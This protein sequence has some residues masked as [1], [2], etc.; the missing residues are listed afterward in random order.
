[1]TD[2]CFPPTAVPADSDA[3]HLMIASFAIVPV[4]V[5]LTIAALT[6]IFGTDHPNGKWE[7]RFKRPPAAT[8]FHETLDPEALG[9][10]NL[11]AKEAFKLSSP[12][13][14]S[15]SQQPEE[16]IGHKGEDKTADTNVTISAV[17]PATSEVDVAVNQPVTMAV[18]S[19][20]ATNPMTWLPSLAYLTTFG[21]ELVMDANLANLLYGMYQDRDLGQTKAGYIAAIYGLLN[22]FSRAFGE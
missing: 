15:R 3:D 20:L 18:L 12:K 13:D 9:L 21:F 11:D 7:D 8:S 16:N 22:I 14:A 2:C 6:L 4:P 5:L 10:A 1:M 19:S 17:D